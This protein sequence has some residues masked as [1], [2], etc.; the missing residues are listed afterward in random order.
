MPQR[1]S[2]LRPIFEGRISLLFVVKVPAANG[3]DASRLREIASFRP[4]AVGTFTTRDPL[5]AREEIAPLA[6]LPV[7]LRYIIEVCSEQ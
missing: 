5:L 3:V 1:Q 2:P 4:Q 7:S 6:E